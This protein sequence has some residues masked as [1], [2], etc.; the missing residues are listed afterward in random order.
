MA[1]A[2]AVVF[3]HRFYAAKS[4][5]RNDPFVSRPPAPSAAMARYI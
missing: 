1:V 2:S 4:L 5:A 3:L